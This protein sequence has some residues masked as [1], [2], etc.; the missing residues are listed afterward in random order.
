MVEERNEMLIRVQEILR[1]ADEINALSAR[2]STNKEIIHKL[3][4]DAAS[5]Q[6]AAA[7]MKDIINTL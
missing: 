5:I 3:A 2:Y 4:R 7:N 1:L 6:A